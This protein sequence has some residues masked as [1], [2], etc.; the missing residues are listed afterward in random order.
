MKTLYKTY[1]ILLLLL[2]SLSC[3]NSSDE[4]HSVPEN[5]TNAQIS[6]E[7]D[8]HA[9]DEQSDHIELSSTQLAD[10]NITIDTISNRNMSGFIQVNGTLGVPPQNEAVITTTIGANISQI[11]VIEG[12]Y[13]TKG[14]VVAYIT[15]PDIITIQTDYLQTLNKLSFLEQDFKRQQ[16]LYDQGV[17]SGRDYQQAKSTYN[18][19]SGLAKGYESQLRLLGLSPQRVKAGNISES[20]PL[21]SPINGYIEKVFVK[22]GQFSQPQTALMD[23]V[24][25][26]HIHLDLMVYEKDVT[27]VK[28]GQTV[29]FKVE[30]LGN[31]ELTAE[32]Y[33]VGKAFEDGPKALHIHAEIENK[34]KKLIPGMYV[35]AQIITKNTTEKAIA[36]SAVFQDGAYSYVFVAKKVNETIW[37]FTPEEV[38]IKNTVNG[39]SSFQFKNEQKSSVLVAQSGAYY[40]ISE[41]KKGDAEHS[42]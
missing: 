42:H 11:K 39:Y 7:V 36:E 4:N 28:N 10:L 37:K 3:K 33:S 30:S 1:G 25:T 9:D 12:D 24:N 34:D 14:Q 20:A 18:S 21:H 40:L 15:H 23:I 17:A 2:I 35:N 8:E 38:I 16:T 19:T 6:P 26:E 41:L 5:K 13:V 29:R 32:I 27:K 22:T 31:T